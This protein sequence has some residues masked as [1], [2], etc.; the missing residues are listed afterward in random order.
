MK[1][2]LAG[3]NTGPFV[4]PD[5]FGQI[6]R[7]AERLGF[8]SVWTI[9]HLVV[10]KVH[11]PYRGTPDGQVPGGDN[12]PINEPLIHLGYAAAITSTLKLATGVLLLPLRHPLY[13]AKQIATLDQLS[14]GRV[15]IGV[16]NGW[17][18]AEFNALGVDF[19]KRG[20]RSEETIAAMRA[21]WREGHASFSGTR[22]SFPEMLSYPQPLRKDAIPIHIGG[23]T[24]AAARRA[25]RIG[26]GF[27]PNTGDIKALIAAM[28]DEA[29][30]HNRNPDSIE[31]TLLAAEPSLEAVRAAAG[32]GANRVLL[33]APAFEAA[34]LRA[35][36]ERIA[37]EIIA[38]L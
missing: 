18:E 12:L 5:L 13:L 23:Y 33:R 8:E 37:T 1:I 11:A 25:G 31:I 16:S 6:A 4:S 15:I 24:E 36:M 30:K 38:K 14:N 3:V 17:M 22:V 28:R 26:D 10:P 19:G 35:G 9:E 29:R 20:V 2:G 32:L 34:A 27:F 21:L 7:D